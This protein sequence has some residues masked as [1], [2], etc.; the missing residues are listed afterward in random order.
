MNTMPE[1]S[2][3][4]PRNNELHVIFG[5]GPLGTALT[6]QL[7]AEGKRVRVIN[8]SG[9][10]QVPA[11]VEVAKGDATD[12]ASTRAVCTG[13]TVVYNCANAPY[14]QW[15]AIFPKI[16][17]GIIEGAA[18]ASARLI[19]AENVYMYGEVHGPMTDETPYNA[20]TRKGRVRA[21]MATALLE[22]HRSGKVRAAIGRASDYYGP[23]VLD[24]M[25][26]DRVFYPVLTG[27]KVSLLGSLDVPHTLTYIDDFARG[28][29]VLGEREEALGQVWH[30]PNAETLTMRQ[31]LTLV[32]EEAQHTP[33]MGTI[34]SILLKGL[35]LF[36]PMLREVAEMLYEFEQPFVVD[37]SKYEHTFGNHS[38]PHRTAI[39]DTLAWFRAHPK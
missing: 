4:S 2:M 30:T 17:A 18:S 21:E 7:V 31:F 23:G 5:T 39:R 25:A 22:A 1:N 38:T 29:K 33:N 12:P 3:I 27:Q 13:A 24:S 16:Q 32:F 6:K 35:G 19:S 36:D 34:P 10:A 20:H 14:T 28:L 9:Q 11:G 37:H 15:P 26:G 8:R